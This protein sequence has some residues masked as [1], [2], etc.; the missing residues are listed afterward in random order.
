MR[1]VPF[2]APADTATYGRASGPFDNN[3]KRIGLGT[4]AYTRAASAAA[5][6]S[7]EFI[8]WAKNNM[9]KCC[10]VIIFGK[11]QCGGNKN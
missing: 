4:A 2:S 7:K 5:A 3:A 10:C 1:D 9:T 6:T 11:A 8:L